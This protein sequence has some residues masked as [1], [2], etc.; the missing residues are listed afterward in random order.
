MIRQA[1]INDVR[2]LVE[3]SQDYHK[4]HW[5]G[6]GHTKFDPD[7]TFDN[8]RT[9][10]ASA[11]TNVVVAEVPEGLVGYTVGVAVPLHW[12]KQ[13]RATV[14][15]EYIEKEYRSQGIFK[16]MVDAQIEWA[17]SL[18]CVDIHIGDGATY[19]GKFSTVAKEM[20][21]PYI[22]TDA[23]RKLNDEQN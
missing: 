23:Y 16:Q 8:F 15:Y 1:N 22:G 19:N 20:G 11:Q 7:Y 6:E 13:L 3:L 18:G 10:I 5:M 4:Q 12:T 14:I 2:T 17:K 21:F 9:Y